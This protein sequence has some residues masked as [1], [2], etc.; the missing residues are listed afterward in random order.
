M[1]SVS[2]SPNEFIEIFLDKT[3]PIRRLILGFLVNFEAENYERTAGEWL[4][5]VDH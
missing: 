4:A 1:P 2:L 5:V 3:C